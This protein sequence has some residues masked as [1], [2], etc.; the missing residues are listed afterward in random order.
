MCGGV[1]VPRIGLAALSSADAKGPSGP[2]LQ[3]DL[4]TRWRGCTVWSLTS[5]VLSEYVVYIILLKRKG[6]A[7][8]LYPLFPVSP[9]EFHRRAS[10][11][12]S[13]PYADL[14]NAIS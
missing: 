5:H 2:R 7:I 4:H 14:I 13:E 1:N 11:S 3:A 6:P 8:A 9:N 10:A 12:H